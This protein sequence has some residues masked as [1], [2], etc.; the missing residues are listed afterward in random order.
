MKYNDNMTRLA[1][2]IRKRNRIKTNVSK[3]DSPCQFMTGC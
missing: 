3:T 2:D 1:D